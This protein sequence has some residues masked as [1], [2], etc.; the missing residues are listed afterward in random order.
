MAIHAGTTR[1]SIGF[2][3][4]ADEPEA[5]FELSSIATVLL[6]GI[7]PVPFSKAS[8]TGLAIADGAGEAK[9]SVRGGWFFWDEG[10]S[11]KLAR[12]SRVAVLSDEAD[13]QPASPAR[14][15]RL[16]G[17]A[18]DEQT[19]TKGGRDGRMPSDLSGGVIIEN[20]TGEVTR[21]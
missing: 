6:P 3:D 12:G 19:A 8:G 11:V 1:S 9:G 10:S 2:A 4:F 18:R 15:K 16:I 17:S 20:V 7:D 5:T 13:P 14:I 21:S